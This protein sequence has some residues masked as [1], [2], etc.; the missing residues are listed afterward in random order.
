[1][2]L[3]TP[4]IQ[5][6]INRLIIGK[7]R[8]GDHASAAVGIAAIIAGMYAAIPQNKR[9]SYGIV[10]TVKELGEHLFTVLKE[11][12]VS[13]FEATSTIFDCSI[14]TESRAVALCILSHYGVDF[15]EKALPYFEKAA[16]DDDWEM[17]EISQILF[18]KLIKEHASMMQKFLIK[19]VRSKDENVRRFV[20]ETLRPVCENKWFYK[21][22][23]YSLV[24]IRHL[25]K[26]NKAYPRTSAGNNLSDLARH[27][28][29]MVYKI[30]EELVS[31]GDKNSYWIA[32]RACRNLVKKE[33][34]R[35]MKLLG[36]ESYKYKDRV[37]VSGKR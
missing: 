11:N 6:K 27:L 7:I 22:P 13:V 37:V 15:P 17:R 36:T 21:D 33:P 4:D 23:E 25:F 30:V 20:G 32:Y 18:R 35:V 5:S 10:H 19:L 34:E 26:E 1:M 12:N 8:R 16:A 9:V 24:V 2:Q 29:E 31:S 14:K 3:I 28:P